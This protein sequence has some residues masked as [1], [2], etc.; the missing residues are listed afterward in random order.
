LDLTPRVITGLALVWVTLTVTAPWTLRHGRAPLA[1]LIT[2]HAGSLVC[3]QR[4]ERSFHLAGVQMPV[5]ARCFG[6]YASGAAGL[7]AAWAWRRRLSATATRTTLAI[8]VLPIAVTVAL[9]W[10]GAISTTNVERFLTG[11]PAGFAFGLVIVWSLRAHRPPAA[12]AL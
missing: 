9:E 8:A 4:P 5:C 11:L 6:L 1:T 2:Y 3:H 10:A 7:L 12:D